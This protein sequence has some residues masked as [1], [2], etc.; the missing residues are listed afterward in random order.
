MVTVLSR[1]K[2]IGNVPCALWAT[3]S[4]GARGPKATAL[5]AVGIS[6]ALNGD[7]R[8]Q[9]E[10]NNDFVIAG[11]LAHDSRIQDLELNYEH[12]IGID[13]GK[14][15]IHTG[16]WRHKGARCYYSN[17]SG[18][19]TWEN[20]FDGQEARTLMLGQAPWA[21]G[22]IRREE[23]A[24]MHNSSS[25]LYAMGRTPFG[26]SLLD[27]L[28]SGK[29]RVQA[30]LV[31]LDAHDCCLVEGSLAEGGPVAGRKDRID[32]R[33]WLDPRCG[34]MPRRTEEYG[35]D[36]AGHLTA[37]NIRSGHQLSEVSPG[38]WL[39]L[40]ITEEGIHLEGGQWARSAFNRWRATQITVNGGM[41]DEKLTVQFPPGT[42]IQDYPRPMSDEFVEYVIAADG[43]ADPHGLAELAKQAMA[44]R[45][46]G[47]TQ[48]P[49][50]ATTA[51][52][53]RLLGSIVAGL[54][55]CGLVFACVRGRSRSTSSQRPTP[56]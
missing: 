44:A 42:Y 49:Q 17:Q 5:L 28:E 11:I 1:C 34:F 45:Q 53:R 25:F 36:Q 7:V 8:G 40:S 24:F 22:M 18:K 39:P 9:D 48:A 31:R 16:T 19:L 2:Q 54:G 23:P 51:R 46:A 20:S 43:S 21:E 29:A 56:R 52:S 30:Q 32:Y 27:A 13:S 4:R 14:P 6:M 47:Q 38:I 3:T 50:Y 33:Y 10:I 26:E 41:R 12:Q 15:T 35:Y 55:I 37:R